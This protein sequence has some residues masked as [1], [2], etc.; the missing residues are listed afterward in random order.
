MFE[1]NL[2]K[3]GDFHLTSQ[4]CRAIQSMHVFGSLRMRAC[5][6][7]RRTPAPAALR[8][9]AAASARPDTARGPCRAAGLPCWHQLPTSGVRPRPVA[10]AAG[11]GGVA[12]RHPPLRAWARPPALGRGSRLRSTMSIHCLPQNAAG[13]KP[14]PS[15]DRK[16]DLE[17]SLSR[18]RFW[19]RA[20]HHIE[21]EQ[22]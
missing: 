22:K 10:H 14:G 7:S 1:W 12:L 18:A 3:A 13:A 15:H 2:S 8:R 19:L 4:C 11:T 17:S 16:C 9:P 20:E 21:P 6:G 5:A